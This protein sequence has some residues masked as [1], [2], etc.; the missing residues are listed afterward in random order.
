MKYCT[1][2]VNTFY[3]SF[4]APVDCLVI[5]NSTYSGDNTFG[6]S[7]YQIN[8]KGKISVRDG[9]LVS[10][11]LKKGATVS[12][13]GGDNVTCF[14]LP[15]DAGGGYN[16]FRS[17]LQRHFDP[18]GGVN[19]QSDIINSRSRWRKLSRIHQS[20]INHWER[21]RCA[22]VL[23]RLFNPANRCFSN[24]KVKSVTRLFSALCR[25]D[26]RQSCFSDTPLYLSWQ[27]IQG[28]R[29]SRNNSHRLE[30]KSWSNRNSLFAKPVAANATSFA[31]VA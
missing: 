31:E 10:I 8:N 23:L 21:R 14:Y 28:R 27:E 20:G 19:V 13:S 11:I 12:S 16:P 6:Y 18:R 5:L 7:G 17:M 2:D 24:W 25:R 3:G 15:L 1:G 26:K 9:G 30:S 29:S 22:L 4:T